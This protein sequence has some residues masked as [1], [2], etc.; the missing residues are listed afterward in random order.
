MSPG[1]ASPRDRSPDAAA[2]PDVFAGVWSSYAEAWEPLRRAVEEAAGAH[3]TAIGELEAA[4]A[5]ESEE[6]GVSVSPRARS[7]YRERVASEVLDPLRAALSGAEMATE[8]H[9][10]LSAAGNRARASLPELDPAAGRHLERV[11]LPG[12]R[13]AFRAS[14]R[15][16][17]QWLGRV[18]RAW[19]EWTSGVL[20]TAGNTS[21]RDGPDHGGCGAACLAAGGSL[22]TA[23]DSLAQQVGPVSGSTG[24]TVHSPRGLLRTAIDL[25]GRRLRERLASRDAGQRDTELAARWD[26]W[27]EEAA[28]RLGL[29]RAFV[30]LR[31]EIDAVRARLV[32]KWRARASGVEAVLDEFAAELTAAQQRAHL[33]EDRTGDRA[34]APALLN[35]LEGERAR[36]IQALQ[37]VGNT[38]PAAVNLMAAL[39]DD[40]EEEIASLG[41]AANDLPETL[42]VHNVPDPGDRPTRP[43]RD[44]RTVRFR[45]AALQAFDALRIE[46]I[47]S[48]PSVIEEAMQRIGADIDQLC[49]VAEYGYQAAIAEL[50]ERGGSPSGEP[51]GPV[52]VALSRAEARASE[53]HLALQEATG[54]TEERLN[55]EVAAGVQQLLQ[56][57][58]ADR[59][60]AGY[61]EAR[62]Y[63]ATEVAE[64]LDRWRGRAADVGRRAS[65]SLQA[66]RSRLEPLAG[67]LGMTTDGQTDSAGRRLARADDVV[68]SLPVVYR[69]LFAFKPLT[70]PRLLAGRD[71]ALADVDAMWKRREQNDDRSLLIVA[72][73]G[74]GI[75]SF[76]NIAAA[77][78]S[79]APR[80]ST[81]HAHAARGAF[82]ERVREEANLVAALSAWLDID[83]ASD[84]DGL[85]GA[86]LGAQAGAVPRVVI[87]EGLEHLH[88]RVQG[89]AE[90]FERFL[91]FMSRT[92]SRVF[93]VAGLSSSAWQLI[94]KRSSPFV[95]DIERMMLGELSPGDLRE[96][97]LARHRLS[98]LP[99]RFAEPQRRHEALRRRAR[100]LRGTGRQ[101]EPVEADYFQQLH[102]ASLGSIRMAMFHW[103]RSADFDTIEG[104]LLVKPLETLTPFMKV[105]DL[106]QSFALKA[107]LDHGTLTVGEYCE[108]AR[109]PE[110]DNFHLF[111]SMV[112]LH[113]IEIA[114]DAADHASAASARYRIRPLMTGVVTAHLKSLNILH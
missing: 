56:R 11:V 77:R 80:S 60:T 101:Q 45:E 15:R 111:R 47:R 41:A 38:L 57:V 62:S 64:D 46:R 7:R 29:C 22:Q 66:V 10:A 76:L 103:L 34:G 26:A 39:T 50:S 90:L 99:L 16:R 110:R 85:A 58:L 96:A 49:E 78:L 55:Q 42:T 114:G 25:A 61:L 91:T 93:W 12:Q 24:E 5:G 1:A 83:G 33:L 52:A 19:H 88:M 14:Q 32:R 54:R 2:V 31:G 3:A 71:H 4:A 105:L 63:L 102:R 40:V 59:L 48:A 8:L 43:G 97:I 68:R 79:A 70:D 67:I 18:E 86:V 23:L 13:R 109:R 75:T 87:L 107:L 72:Q 98:G 100:L 65:G 6:E 17:A 51:V 106:N 95:G 21:A 104:S 73:P 35:A 92:E 53:A 36:T 74:S 37:R 27:A 94:E 30:D 28:A 84:L 82:K 113:V 112:D 69:R 89:G 9:D 108:I 20:A 44:S 81:T